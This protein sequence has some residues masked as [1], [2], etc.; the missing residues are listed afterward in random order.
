MVID[1]VAPAGWGALRFALN[2]MEDSVMSP[3]ALARPWCILEAQ[4]EGRVF[5]PALSS[6]L[7]HSAGTG[8]LLWVNVQDRQKEKLTPKVIQLLLESGLC[9]G[10]LLHGLEAFSKGQS[11]ALW[12]R[13]WQLASQKGGTHLVWLH[14]KPH[15]VIGFDIRLEWQSQGIY[16]IKKGY[17]YFHEQRLKKALLTQSAAA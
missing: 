12:G 2:F 11:P 1:A 16:E 13:R 17:G 9:A 4:S 8:R 7:R 3:E 6:T 15:H 10:I 14:Q 5:L